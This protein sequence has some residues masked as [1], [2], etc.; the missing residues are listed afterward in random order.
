MVSFP[1]NLS[2][3][4]SQYQQDGTKALYSHGSGSYNKSS[5]YPN[6]T[7]S[8][9]SSNPKLIQQQHINN[10]NNYHRHSLNNLI[11]LSLNTNSP[12]QS[13]TTV[14]SNSSSSVLS[15]ENIQVKQSPIVKNSKSSIVDINSRLEFLCL[16]M[17]EQAIN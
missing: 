5:S 8:S 16:Q 9:T 11:T 4:I 17:T 2:Q 13:S 10:S 14:I 6:F 3:Q 15:K 12:Q 7:S 1:V